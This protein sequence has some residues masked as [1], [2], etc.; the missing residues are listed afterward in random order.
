VSV[1]TTLSA[2]VAAGDTTISVASA[3]DFPTEQFKIGINH[4][5]LLVTGGFGTTTWTVSR[6]ESAFDLPAIFSEDRFNRVEVDT[7]GMN[8]AG[9]AWQSAI[10]ETDRVFRVNYGNATIEDGIGGVAPNSA[11]PRL[12]IGDGP[13]SAELKFAFILDKAATTNDIVLEA[14]P[15]EHANST[16]DRYIC[17]I[18]IEPDND[19][20]LNLFRRVSG[21]DTQLPA[22]LTT[23]AGLFAVDTWYWVRT[24]AIGDGTTTT[25]NGKFWKESDGEPGTWDES[26]ADTN[27]AMQ[28]PGYAAMRYD[29]PSGA[30]DL[31]ITLGIRDWEYRRVPLG[32]AHASGDRI[33]RVDPNW[34]S[35]P[36]ATGFG[37]PTGSPPTGSQYVETGTAGGTLWT[38]VGAV[39][40]K[41]DLT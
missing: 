29:T 17:R 15:R 37:P 20:T 28:T 35:P 33:E 2:A 19:M 24:Q 36:I 41:E 10:S 6:D 14:R 8:D 1:F 27:A 23:K 9:Q 30:T 26:E 40:R 18:R 22:S 5:E 4:E 3:L 25:V 31:P 16:R 7:W 39:W 34:P 12:S 13:L 32:R 21:V 38:R 11:A